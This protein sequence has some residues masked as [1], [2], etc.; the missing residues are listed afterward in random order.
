MAKQILTVDDS[1]TMREMVSFTLKAAGYDILEAEDGKV[2][3][4]VLDGKKIDA[5]IADLNMPNMNGFELIK[6][7]RAQPAYQ[8]TPILMLT[9]EGD[10]S[11]KEEGK[12][13]GAT[14]W[15]VKPF[16]PEKLVEVVKK[17]CPL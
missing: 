14:G 3:L 15:I 4:S 8:F 2:A 17:V 10:T 5:V 13:A 16:D 11:K 12:A 9:T 7:L 1:K 6:A